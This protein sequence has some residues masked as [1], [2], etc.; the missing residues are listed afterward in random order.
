MHIKIYVL[1]PELH[2]HDPQ[3]GTSVPTSGSISAVRDPFTRRDSI[4]VILDNMQIGK[5]IRMSE[6][7]INDDPYLCFESYLDITDCQQLSTKHD[8]LLGSVKA[9]G[10]TSGLYISEIILK[11]SEP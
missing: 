5:A 6:I 11:I 3:T 10:W 8:G 9:C 7:Q 4:P 1:G 2:K